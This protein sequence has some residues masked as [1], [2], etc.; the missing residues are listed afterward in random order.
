MSFPS[1]MLQRIELIFNEALAVPEGDRQSLIEARCQ[2]DAKLLVE[3]STLLDACV[4]EEIVAAARLQQTRDIRANDAERIR[5][6]AYEIDRL[7]GRGGMGAVYLAHRADGNFEQQVAI[8]LIDLPLAT[9]LFRERLRMERQILAG[10]NHPYIARLIDGGVTTDGEPF[11]VMEYVDGTPINRF[12]DENAL[13]LAQRLLL[14]RNVCEAVQFAHQNLVIHRDLK[15]DNIF[16]TAEGTPRLLDFGTAKLLSPSRPGSES[17]LTRQGFQSFTPQYASPEQV[18]GNAITTASDTYSLGVLLYL[19]L[20]GKLPYELKEFTT[21]EMLRVI[22]EEPPHRP[23]HGNGLHI[24][25]DLEAIAL[26]ALRKEPSERYLTAHQF[27]ADVQAYLDGKPVSARHG[28]YSYRAGKFIHRHRIGLAAAG[29]VI[30]SLAAGVEGVLWQA[31]VANA[32]R[33]KAEAQAAD[34]RQLSNS[35]LSEIDEAIRKLPGS[36]GAQQLL[37]STVLEHLDRSTKDSR[38][39]KLLLDA[40]TAYIQLGNVQ[41]N[42]YSEHTGDT[43]GAL[44]SLDKGVAITASLLEEQPKNA[45]V[46]HALAWAHRSRSEIL[47]GI[48]RTQ[49]AVPEM[50][51]AIALFDEL[52][53]GRGSS[54]D[55]LLDSAAAHGRLGAELGVPYWPSLSDFP[56]A[57]AE[58]LKAREIYQRAIAVDPN[59]IRVL[60]AMADNHRMVGAIQ[61]QT[62]PAGALPELRAAISGIDSLHEQAKYEMAIRRMQ[63]GTIGPYAGALIEIGHYREALAALEQGQSIYREL[64]AA[65]PKNIRAVQDVEA[66][67]SREAEAYQERASGIFPEEGANPRTDAANALKVLLDQRSVLEQILRVEPHN[68]NWESKLGMVLIDIG[69]QQR[70]LHL[71]NGS[72]DVEQRGLTILK[73]VAQRPDAQAY[74]LFDAANGLITVEPPSLREPALAV[75]YAERIVERSS[76]HNPEFLLTLAN[77]YRANG[78]TEKARAAAKRGLELLPP[79]TSTTVMSRVRKLLRAQLK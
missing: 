62:D 3:V 25:T 68:G 72:L 22:C 5:V 2:G 27:A 30:A 52:A 45:A 10:L 13:S 77:A 17:E 78:E 37:V 63:S 53:A 23:G 33:R 32:E 74:Q 1:E 73:E 20:T 71:E 36:T 79:E 46:K 18:L 19:L 47:F 51:T 7:I 61:M 28:T 67:L 75:K 40:A 14:F 31:K 44:A 42:M 21:S 64:L 57:L 65:D 58:Y 12:C 16:V 26:K 60:Q 55:T 59:N 69:R 29:L 48:G 11:L 6:G 66:G 54:L 56:G 8:K 43:Q 50:R 39:P 15:P 70:A 9:D 38:D 4:A 76:Y 24:D 34:L 35:L 49:E 41:G